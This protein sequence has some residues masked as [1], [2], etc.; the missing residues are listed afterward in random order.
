MSNMK[1]TRSRSVPSGFTLVELLVVIAIIGVLVS[2]LL[3]A[4]QAAREA[5]RRMQCSNN[6]KQLALALHNYESTFTMLPPSRSAVDVAIE[7][8]ASNKSAYQSWTT[9]VLPY[10]EQSGLSELVDFNYAWSSLK[11]RP[12]VSVQL[13]VY[14][15]PSTPGTDRRDP[16]WVKGAAAGDYGSVNEIKKKFYTSVAGLADPGDN[17]RSGVLAKGTSNR[18]RDILD[19]TSNTI[20]LAEAAGQPAVWTSKGQMTAAMFALYNDDKVTSSGGNF[21]AHD[22]TGWADPDCGFSINGASADGLTV[23]G[24]YMMNR[25]NV[26]EVFS[27]HTGGAQFAIADGSVRFM[28]ESIDMMSFVNSVTRAGGEVKVFEQ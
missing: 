20:L 6:L 25:I 24:P 26:S 21:N 13:S 27:F 15:C 22:G 4:V 9:M 11:N 8:N 12:A 5:A 1:N 3:P 2:L 16:V 10:I 23:Y 19:G 17:A 28:S 7:D 14:T 18:F